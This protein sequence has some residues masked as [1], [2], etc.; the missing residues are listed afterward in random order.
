MAVDAAGDDLARAR[1]LLAQ[2][3]FADAEEAARH[4]IRLDPYSAPAHIVLASALT[5]QGK[6]PSARAAAERAIAIDPDLAGGLVALASAWLAERRPEL[7]EIAARRAVALDPA[8][9]DAYMVLGN[10]LLERGATT[11]AERA[12]DAAIT[13]EPVDPEAE[14]NWKRSRAPVVVAISI[15]G[16]LA[17]EALRLLLDRFTDRRVAIALLAIT[18]VLV[19]ALLIALAIQRRRLSRLSPAERLELALESRR[20]RARGLGHYRVH[21]LLLAVAIGGL[22][23]ATILFAIGQKASLQMAVGDCFSTERQAMIEQIAAIPCQLPHDYEVFAVLA[24]PSPPGAPY[25]GLDVLHKQLRVQCEQLYEGYV[26]VPFSRKAPTDVN[27][28]VPAESYWRLN[29]RTEFCGLKDWHGRQLVG[30]RRRGS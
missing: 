6:G 25:P 20:R 18:F 2:R 8:S 30:S 24:E 1:T 19:V 28:F 3:K 11:E 4:E 27:T 15:A 23:I 10:A 14:R 5:G 17:F 16:I 7:A 21:L 13:L 26:G 29:I 12:F 22:S 9:A